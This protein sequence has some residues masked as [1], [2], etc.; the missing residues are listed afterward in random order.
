[1]N[2][3]P[4]KW[5]LFAIIVL[6]CAGVVLSGTSLLLRR[7]WRVQPIATPTAPATAPAT[8]KWPTTP[9]VD[10]DESQGGDDVTV[11]VL[12]LWDRFTKEKPNGSQVL[13]R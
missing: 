9:K 11:L 7:P 4:A 12:W 3:P 2:K 13:E 10:G 5:Q 1:M 8:E 6:S